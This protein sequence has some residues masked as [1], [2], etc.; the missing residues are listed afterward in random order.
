MNRFK[1]DKATRRKL[2]LVLIPV[3]ISLAAIYYYVGF[4]AGFLILVV[5]VVLS[6]LPLFKVSQKVSY[7]TEKSEDKIED[8]FLGENPILTK[9]WA[10][11]EV[12]LK[13]RG[14][15][16][17]KLETYPTRL[18]KLLD[19]TKELDI[20]V[21]KTDEGYKS[22]ISDTTSNIVVVNTSLE[23]VE[24]RIQVN[25]VSK[26]KTRQGLLNA[27]IIHLQEDYVEKV[28]NKNDYDL[29]S[30]DISLRT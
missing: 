26:I 15:G 10:D 8:D 17:F 25:E 18:H 5:L 20:T 27:L 19:R 24:E 7:S 12:K 23:D 21:E 3:I 4:S 14:E 29:E 1:L 6:S 22:V 11:Q 30:Y 13:S 16:E 9:M 2:W 28:L